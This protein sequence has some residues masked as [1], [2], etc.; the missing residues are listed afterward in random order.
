MDAWHRRPPSRLTHKRH[1]AEALLDHLV[2]ALLEMERHVEAERL[3][4]LNYL[5]PATIAR[6]IHPYT[7]ICPSQAARIL[8]VCKLS[9][10]NSVV[11]CLLDDRG[12]VARTGA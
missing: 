4:I 12:Q 7:Q 10:R 6:S 2:G 11:Q 3:G 9:D 1:A 8:R 5:L